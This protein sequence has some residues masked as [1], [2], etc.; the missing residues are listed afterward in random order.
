MTKTVEVS[1]FPPIPTMGGDTRQ[2]LVEERLNVVIALREALEALGNMTPH[3]RN[4]H[5]MGQAY[6]DGAREEHFARM[7]MISDLKDQIEAEGI[8]LADG[9]SE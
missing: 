8:A 7:K 5:F 9:G 4:Y 6:Y 2:T 3:G 1:K